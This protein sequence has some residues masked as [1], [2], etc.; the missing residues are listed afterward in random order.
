MSVQFKVT[1]EGEVTLYP[2]IKA[3]CDAANVKQDTVYHYL[4]RKKKDGSKNS[5]YITKSGI[6]I[7]K[8]EE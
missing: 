8:L 4:T 5:R 6:I 3:A 7:Q 1:K 2:S